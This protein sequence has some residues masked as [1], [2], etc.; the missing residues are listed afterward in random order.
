MASVNNEGRP[1]AAGIGAALNDRSV[2][3][4]SGLSACDEKKSKVLLVLSIV[5][6][7]AFADAVRG[8]LHMYTLTAKILAMLG[9]VLINIFA[10]ALLPRRFNWCLYGLYG[11]APLI[12]ASAQSATTGYLAGAFVM[13]CFLE[14]SSLASGKLHKGS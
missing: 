9:A 5:M 14:L 12:V 2:E 10:I 13:L 1:E 11:A 7:V 8:N 6:S 3:R 4:N